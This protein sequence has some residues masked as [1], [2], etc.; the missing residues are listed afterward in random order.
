VLKEPTRVIILLP[1]SARS[2]LPEEV[3]GFVPILKRH[4]YMLLANQPMVTIPEGTVP[5]P[6][7]AV[8][9]H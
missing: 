9:G 8:L 1:E 6:P 5:S 2:K 7:S 3:N 4:G